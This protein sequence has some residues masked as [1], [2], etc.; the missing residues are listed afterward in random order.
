MRLLGIFTG[1]VRRLGLPVT[2]KEGCGVHAQRTGCST[3]EGAKLQKWA[4]RGEEEKI[5]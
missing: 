4:D 1:V 5:I 2:Y 3:G